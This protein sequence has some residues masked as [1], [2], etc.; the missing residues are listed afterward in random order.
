MTQ[1]NPLPVLC[2]CLAL[3]AC[4]D[5]SASNPAADDVGGDAAPA[6]SGPDGGQ[7]DTDDASQGV[8]GA[9]TGDVPDDVP[10]DVADA[11]LVDPRP[12][13]DPG[14]FFVGYR[15]LEATY[16]PPGQEE[17]RTLRLAVWYPTEAV[18][19]ERS[20]YRDLIPRDGIWA[21]APPAEGPFPV[22]M[23]SHGSRAFA[24]QSVFLTE[25]L[26]SH[27]WLVV[28][29]DHLGNTLFDEDTGPLPPALFELRPRDI[30]AA[31]DHV[32]AL[33]ADDPLAGAVGSPIA[34]AGHSFGGYTMLALGG[35]QFD[36]ANLQENCEEEFGE[37]LCAYLTPEVVERLTPGLRDDRIETIIPMAPGGYIAYRDGIADI[38]VPVL[39]MTGGRDTFTPDETEGDPVW[40]ALDGPFD[41]RLAIPGAGHFTF[42]D[43]C[44]L[45]LPVPGNDSCGPENIDTDEAHPVLNAFV[46]AFLHGDYAVFDEP[47]PHPGIQIVRK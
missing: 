47:S 23:F 4:S 6:D 24:E 17:P 45:G 25:F 43:V 35:G 10:A 7:P 22:L 27:G 44:R 29:P 32:S 20:F 21:D 12:I 41:V 9:D 46:L 14:P 8:D 5:S 40:E 36:L 3:S 30:S 31:L 16:Q 33:P 13:V 18:T 34:A 2:L 26:A 28:A 19:G 38:D 11:A 1:L 42:S 37:E 15:Q 39:L